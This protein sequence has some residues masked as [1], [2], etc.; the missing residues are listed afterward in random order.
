MTTTGSQALRTLVIYA[1]CVPLALMIGYLVANPLDWSTIAFFGVLLLVIATP[2]LLKFH[3]AL[4]VTTLSMTA[5]AFFVPGRPP[6][7]ELVALISLGI[8]ILQYALSRRAGFLHAPTITRPLIFICVV[9]LVTAKFTGG[10]GFNLLGGESVGGRRYVDILCGAAVFFGLIA[11]RIPLHKANIYTALFVLSGITA[12]LSHVAMYL[13]PAF[14]FILYLFPSAGTAEL[15]PEG[16]IGR[17]GGAALA[18]GALVSYILA[19]YG[20]RGVFAPGHFWRVIGLFLC[21][22]ASLFSGFRGSLIGITLLIVFLGVL[23]GVYKSRW[24]PVMVLCGI[25]AAAVTIPLVPKLPFTF[26]RTI[27]FLPVEISPE[28][29]ASAESTSEWRLGIW[30]EALPEVPKYL[31]LGKGLSINTEKWL[32]ANSS[33]ALGNESGTLLA[34]DYHSGPLSVIIPFGIWG[35][36]GFVWFVWAG[37]RVLYLNYRFGDPALR[38]INAYLLAAFLVELFQFCF[39]MGGFQPGLIRF[40]SIFGFSVAL[41]GGVRKPVPALAPQPI[42]IPIRLRIKPAAAFSR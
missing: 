12:M 22:V 13:G 1:I 26:Q 7:W 2:I 5:Y 20:L 31:F 34:G 15:R 6:L 10:I 11:R 27:S 17:I 25:L 42:P 4:L 32:Q 28:A 9:V 30:K 39:I 24:M 40:C 14:N 29:R 8:S 23:E 37:S 21:I 16:E 41:N 3:H 38:T 18:G 33:S 35:V 19:R 36:I